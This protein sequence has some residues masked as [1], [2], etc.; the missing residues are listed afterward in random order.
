MPLPTEFPDAGGGGLFWGDYAGVSA[1]GHAAH[2]IWSDT[3]AAEVFLCPGTGVFGVPPAVCVPGASIAN[4]Q[5][6][7][8]ASVSSSNEDEQ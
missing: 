6:I 3:R 4:D 2:P 1:L 7:Y 5:D 8:T